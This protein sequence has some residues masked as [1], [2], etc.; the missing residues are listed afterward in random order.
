M[1]N[2][3]M[4]VVEFQKCLVNKK[5]KESVRLYNAALQTPEKRLAIWLSCR[6]AVG[7]RAARY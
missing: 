6:I 1:A 4:Q 7:P 2:T 3:F 5:K